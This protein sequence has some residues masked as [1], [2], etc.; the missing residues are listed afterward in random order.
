M[1]S[2]PDSLVWACISRHNS[3]LVKKGRGRDATYFSS[4]AGNVA[5]LSTFKHSGVANSNTIDVRVT[6]TDEK[7]GAAITLLKK[8]AS[9]A[10]SKPSKSTQSSLLNKSVRSSVSTISKQ[11]ARADLTAAA[12]AKYLMLSNGKAVS[13]ELR[14]KTVIKRGRNSSN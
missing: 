10:G 6:G 7:K 4:E 13:K 14:K 5:S 11:S 2:A 3:F 8:T 9:K 1:V 12:N